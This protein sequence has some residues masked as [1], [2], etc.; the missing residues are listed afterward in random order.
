MYNHDTFTI[1]QGVLFRWTSQRRVKDIVAVGY[2]QRLCCAQSADKNA[3][4]I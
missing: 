1:L 2:S 4:C 3:L